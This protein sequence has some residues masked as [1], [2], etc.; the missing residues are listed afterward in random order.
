LG[1]MTTAVAVYFI[2]LALGIEFMPWGWVII[3]FSFFIGSGLQW[4]CYKRL[5]V[6]DR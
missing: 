5:L 1:A 4:W 3:V 6:D 2:L